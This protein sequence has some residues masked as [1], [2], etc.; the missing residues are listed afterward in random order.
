MALTLEDVKKY[1]EKNNVGTSSGVES[2]RAARDRLSQGL[3]A[4]SQEEQTEAPTKFSSKRILPERGRTRNLNKG[5]S[6]IRGVSDPE[7]SESAKKVGQNPPE[8]RIDNRNI[9]R[10]A[11]AAAKQ[12]GVSYT[13]DAEET[14][15]T[16]GRAAY[17]EGK[18]ADAKAL[19]EKANAQKEWKETPSFH[20]SMLAPASEEQ[21]SGVDSIPVYSGRLH[22]K[23]GAGD[24][25]SAAGHAAMGT[26]SGMSNGIVQ[27]AKAFND[28]ARSG[29]ELVSGLKTT[30]GLQP[31]WD[32]Y[33][34]LD[35]NAQDQVA[36]DIRTGKM[37]EPTYA[38]ISGLTQQIPTVALAI[39]SGGSSVAAEGAS[40]ALGNPSAVEAGIKA[41]PQMFKDP[42]FLFS[43]TQ[44]FGPTYQEARESGANP[45]QAFLAAVVDA[46][47]ES[48]IEVGGGLETALAEGPVTGAKDLIGR[49]GKS[50]LEEAGEEIRQDPFSGLARMTYDPGV[51]KVSLTDEDAVVNP[52]RGAK[53]AFYAFITSALSG[54]VGTTLRTAQDYHTIGTQVKE[55]GNLNSMLLTAMDSQ[56]ETLRDQAANLAYQV[57]SGKKVSSAA[58][59]K[60]A[61]QVAEEVNREQTAALQENARQW[62]E[63]HQEDI[64]QIDAAETAWEEAWKDPEKRKA[65]LADAEE[66]AQKEQKRNAAAEAARRDAEARQEALRKNAVQRRKAAAEG[67]QGGKA[68]A[69]VSMAE[70]L[71]ENGR[72][73]YEYTLEK[74][75][76]EEAGIRPAFLAC[77]TYGLAGSPME[78]VPE[79]FKSALSGDAAYRAWA[80]GQNDAAVSLRNDQEKVKFASLA[81]EDSGLVYDDFVNEAVRSGRSRVDVNEENRTYLSAE[82]AEQI[83]E[84]AKA[85]GLRVQFADS[86]RGGTANAQISGDTILIEK[87]NPNPVLAIAGHEFGHRLQEL[88][89]EEYRRFRESV[90]EGRE[91][92]VRDKAAQYAK[93]GVN[94]TYEEAMN[95]VANDQAGLLMDGGE[96]L[97]R[98]I[99][100]HR[101]DRTLLQ[102]MRDAIRSFID[103]V[104]GKERKRLETAEGKL[105][106]ALKAA[107]KEVKAL[108][109]KAA[110]DTMGA[111]KYSL[112]E[113]GVD[114]REES[115]AGRIDTEIVENRTGAGREFEQK[116]REGNSR[117]GGKLAVSDRRRTQRIDPSFGER[118]Y[119]TWTE[120]HIIEPTSGTV[121]Y[122]EQQ[123]AAGYGIPSFVVSDKAWEKSGVDAPAFSVHGQIYL[124]ETIPGTKGGMVAPHEV[125]HVMRQVE[126]APYLDFLE[127][128]PT[129]LNM[130]NGYVRAALELVAAHRGKTLDTIDPSILYDEFNAMMYGSIAVGNTNIFQ[131]G[132]GSGMF[133]DFDAYAKELTELHERFKAENGKGETKFSLKAPVEETRDLVAVHN[134]TEENL[135]GA[136]K[137][138]GMPM[139]SIAVVKSETG[140][141]KYGP[142]SL[143]FGKDTIDPQF[144]RSNRVYGGDGWTPTAPQV[145]YRVD[146]RKMSAFE[147]RIDELSRKTAGGM[148]GGSSVL[149]SL[150]V[151]DASSMSREALA[152]KL[153]ASDTVR[154][155][156][157]A[158][159][160]ISVDPVKKTKEWDRYGNGIL[161]KLVDRVGHQRLAKMVVDLELGKSAETA[162]GSDAGVVDSLLRDYYRQ[163]GEAFLN[164]IA[165]KNNWTADQIEEKRQARI[166]RAMENN[167]TTFTLEN[168]IRHAW[169]MYK[170]GGTTKG[171][172]DRLATSE[173]VREAAG[174]AEVKSWVYDQ[175][176]GVLGEAGI[177]NGKDR[178]TSSGNSRSFAQ[179]HYAYT[180]ENIVKAMQGTQKERGEGIW[181]ASAETLMATAAPEYSSI[182]E[183]RADKGR[184]RAADE[185]EYQEI[186]AKLDAR[187]EE[188]ITGIRK[189]NRALSDNEFEE[190]DRIGTAL[191]DASSGKKTDAAIRKAFRDSGYVISDQLIAKARQLFQEAASAPTEYFE[192]KPQRAVGFDEVLAAVVPSNSSEKLQDALSDRNVR[193]LTYESGNEADRLEKVNSVEDARFSLKTGT[194]TKSYEAV[195]EEN[196]LLREQMKDYRSLK[197]QNRNLKENR[198]YWKGQT[199]T[200]K[201]VTT[202]RKAVEKAAAE[203]LKSYSSE[204][205]VSDIQ[206]RLQNLYDSIARGDEGV[207]YEEAWKRAETIAKAVIDKAVAKESLGESYQELLSYLKDTKIRVEEGTKSDIPDY[208][209]FQ[210]QQKGR[211][212]LNSQDGTGI[213]Q[214]YQELAER[215]P[216]FFDETE[217]TNPSDQLLQI[218]DVADQLR[219]VEEYNPF[220]GDGMDQVVAGAANE[221]L[222]RF[223]DLPQTKKTFADR[224]EAKLNAAKAQGKQQVQ[225][226]REEYKERL[227]K[228]R[229]ANR[230]RVANTID[231][232]RG[233]A[234]QKIQTLKE[235]YA[236]RDAAGREKREIREYKSK[237][238]K[239]ALDLSRRLLNPTDSRHIPES[240]RGPVAAFLS[241]VDFS[242]KKQD[243]KAAAVWQDLR[244]RWEAVAKGQNQDTFSGEYLTIDPELVPRLDELLEKD[245][246]SRLE[247]LSR[248]EAEELWKVTAAIK[249]AVTAANRSVIE[250][251]KVTAAE[252]GKN[253][254]LELSQQKQRYLGQNNKSNRVSDFFQYDMTDST[255]FGEMFGPTMESLIGNLREGHNVMVRRWNEAVEY[256]GELFKNK[257]VWKWGNGYADPKAFK[258]ESG[259]SILL[260]PAQAMSLYLLDKREQGRR[261][262]YGGGITPTEIQGKHKRY[263]QGIR[264]FLT[265]ED[266]AHI[267][268]S[269]TAEQRQVAD[270]IGYFLSHQA[271][272]WGNEA[273]MER[274]GYRK[275]TEENYFPIKTDPNYVRGSDSKENRPG[276][277]A[278]LGMTKELNKAANNPILLEDVF[279]VFSRH[280]TEMAAY[281]AFMNRL[282]DFQAVWNRQEIRSKSVKEALKAVG[283]E[284]ANSYIRNLLV[285]INGRASVERSLSEVL[286]SRYKSG[287]IG[288][289]LR[290]ALQQPTAYTRALEVMKGKYLLKG[291][292]GKVDA[293]TMKEYAPIARWKDW[294]YYETG[295]G[296]QVKD[297]ILGRH[298]PGDRFSE[299]MMA[300]PG[301]MDSLTWG[302]LWKACEYEIADTTDLKPKTDEFYRAVGK[303]F[304]EVID[305]TQVVDSV[306]HR[307]QIMRSKNFGNQLA[308]AFMAEPTKSYNAVMGA[309]RSLQ[310]AK[311]PERKKA[312]VKLVGRAVSA[313]VV[314]NVINALVVSLMDAARDDDRDKDYAE[315]YREALLGEYSKDKSLWDNIRAGLSA[316]LTENLNPLSL[317]PY[318]KDTMN[319]MEGY[320]I[321]RMDMQGISELVSSFKKWEKLGDGRYT[322]AYLL[323]D[324]AESLSKLTGIPIGNLMRELSTMANTGISVA[325]SFGADTVWLRYRLSR[326]MYDV[327]NSQNLGIFTGL[328]WEARQKGNEELARTIYNDLIRSGWSNEKLDQRLQALAKKA[329]DGSDLVSQYLDAEEKGSASGMEKAAEAAGDRGFSGQEFQAAV[330]QERN[331]RKKGSEEASAGQ[332]IQ[333]GYWAG[334][335]TEYS[336]G[337]LYQAVLNGDSASV[338]S[339]RKALEASGKSEKDIDS[340]VKSR[341]RSDLKDS[342]WESG[343]LG[344][345]DV[346]KFLQ[347]LSEW[348]SG[349]DGK[350]Y[351]EKATWK[352]WKET[353]Q[354]GKGEYPEYRKYYDILK[355][356]FGYENAE[357]IQKG[358]GVK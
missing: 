276:A 72:K 156:Y 53:S 280:V 161:Q 353:Y 116:G 68:P 1:R 45:A 294:G 78:N 299:G 317:I 292:A 220:E 205:D 109:K 85:L 337:N 335:E 174:E 14:L 64:K 173:A 232:E 201:E 242:G 153:A 346:R 321:K 8:K 254:V 319:L 164:K 16:A 230:Q 179:L 298:K 208:S 224:Q 96:V 27:T 128:T 178:Y 197:K 235:K 129:M 198:D 126:F 312:A 12:Y 30:D 120:G 15:R 318:L 219:Q 218:A 213:D 148:F 133:H 145:D 243:T 261:H 139:P 297:L 170:D 162:L 157:L 50:A 111:E 259:E 20:S 202:D 98:F 155:A 43:F 204:A 80:S 141:T 13:G 349:T 102:K 10:D 244:N 5:K 199:K 163:S 338:S 274:F 351:L 203:L 144:F 47:P 236:A 316:N 25:L 32:L 328:I 237:I 177:Y 207:S 106:A 152:E 59:G 9:S 86:V 95:E 41:L 28:L 105:E 46:L 282:E 279:D 76:G 149:R 160:G 182:E 289:N 110:G 134:L 180:L 209:A 288:G 49:I 260:T 355:K 330:N 42:Q 190:I 348:D 4:F 82:T 269:L 251:K 75:S 239:T 342:F 62:V 293:E 262:L 252:A 90:L 37:S 172:N 83:N 48:A 193:V 89:P 281:D 165:A 92:E 264:T 270:G 266:A 97:D 332:E 217:Y 357:I 103:K 51:N 272:E 211:L 123:T 69:S 159:R 138:G 240:L 143:V 44:T 81:G 21:P 221:I 94:V 112:K 56:D 196:R 333:D 191:V 249:A 258:L 88:A 245:V 54:G 277:I 166:D 273:S 200:T 175:L 65:S 29:F 222:E 263:G 6:V 18:A 248:E 257:E 290:V 313:Y 311:G 192:A 130:G 122:E 17:G 131:N 231:R 67:Q 176:E 339:I 142:I 307:S 343:S 215:W 36:E 34:R 302:R 241:S 35:Q 223:F 352:K 40:A 308:T 124:K 181:G 320:D 70:Q 229:Q 334:G 314:T 189:T 22:G 246:P 188:L 212:S 24:Y 2:V 121:A 271:A 356:V 350:D 55:S 250:G 324:T 39:L 295:N 158:D 79:E 323:K 136:L 71:G 114:G 119:R 247:N 93:Q 354:G 127:R 325:D 60:M 195:L 226:V 255:R 267:I 87:D 309:V 306:F 84:T 194:I 327:K 345:P 58:V 11:S 107:A 206:D 227:D 296:K 104:T 66:S 265:E 228:L 340:A 117:N 234:D 63:R 135:L 57:K 74:S 171:E 61:L 99:E 300:L 118:P 305:K 322:V 101:S 91:Q 336:Y 210:R 151:D 26:I 185:A 77:Y 3:P 284:G 31:L 33:N 326:T 186:K 19:F 167:V 115:R 38:I 304:T 301:F 147:R 310:N 146:G 275:F 168:I 137:L 150:G 183:I 253:L 7:T 278:G 169:Q 216:E 100:Q 108:Q 73:A 331:R 23:Y 52:V 315:K 303:R 187:I 238:R 291:L 132:K 344:D 287:V 184:L 347:L 268:G 113:D 214:V 341:L 285:D 286:L 125:T 225:K 233:R 329:L 283:G 256:T 154:A 358:K 140:H